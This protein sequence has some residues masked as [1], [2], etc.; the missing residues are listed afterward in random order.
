M[1]KKQSISEFQAVCVHNTENGSQCSRAD[2]YTGQALITHFI[3]ICALQYTT[4]SRLLYRFF[5]LMMIRFVRIGL[6]KFDVSFEASASRFCGE[7]DFLKISYSA[8]LIKNAIYDSDSQ[9]LSDIKTKAQPIQCAIHRIVA[10]MRA[11]S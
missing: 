4:I 5:S 11:T 1:S 3:A 9:S 2:G 8:A 7:C 6:H 10:S